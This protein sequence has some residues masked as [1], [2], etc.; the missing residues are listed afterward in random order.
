MSL[1]SASSKQPIP[2]TH[3]LLLL[4]LPRWRCSFQR[5]RAPYDDDDDEETSAS[6]VNHRPSVGP[7]PASFT[8]RH[9]RCPSPCS[10]VVVG[11]VGS[12]QVRS[13]RLGAALSRSDACSLTRP[14][15]LLTN[16]GGVGRRRTTNVR[17]E[18]LRVR[19]RAYDERTPEPPSAPRCRVDAIVRLDLW[20]SGGPATTTTWHLWVLAPRKRL[21]VVERAAWVSFRSSSIVSPP[22]RRR[23][24]LHRCCTSTWTGFLPPWSLLVCV[25]KPTHT[26]SVTC[27]VQVTPSYVTKAR[28]YVSVVCRS[29][30]CV[31]G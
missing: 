6:R 8:V 18:N 4:R 2:S 29:M 30:A 3:T 16:G 27:S 22:E 26:T 31:R 24:R 5:R 1:G 21:R 13:H 9:S 28:L 10:L 12:G 11:R 15:F 23:R 14:C 20:R 19:I 25:P 7:D 17:L